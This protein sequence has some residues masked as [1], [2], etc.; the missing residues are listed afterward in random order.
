M[1]EAQSGSSLD[2][3]MRGADKGAKTP[4]PN[5]GPDESSPRRCGLAMNLDASTGHSSHG[6]GGDA[7]G[8]VDIKLTGAM[9]G[10]FL[11]VNCV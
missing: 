7:D 2:R 9:P 4:E 11:F 1:P 5:I 3:G 8:A 6:I 10:G